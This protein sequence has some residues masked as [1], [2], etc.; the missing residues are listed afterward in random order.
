MRARK[1]FAQHFLEPVWA[2]KVVE[3]I[4]PAPTDR[5]L[6][7]GPGRGA[8]TYTLAAGVARLVAVELD[9]DLAADLAARRPSNVTLV[10]GDA[11]RVDLDRLL[12]ELAS[13]AGD[14]DD[15]DPGPVAT[16]LRIVGN[17]PYN[18]ASPILIRLLSLERWRSGGIADATF[19]LQEEVADRLLATPGHGE[20]GPLSIAVQTWSQ[21]IRLLALPPGAFRPVPKV[22][23]TLV[24]L[25]F[26]PPPFATDDLVAVEGLVRSVFTLRRKTLANAL[27]P[28]ASGLGRDTATALRTADLDGQ[29]RPE[30]LSLEE[31]ARLSRALAGR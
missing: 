25:P 1:R 3:A 6:E 20:Y 29:R 31:F 19:M 27:R 8:I 15:A 18:V 11:L 2:R 12:A 26:R 10:L 9:R 13:P 23:S 4:A 17:L 5:V 14:E 24:R 16:R 22:R 30:T 28:F 21:P 7:I